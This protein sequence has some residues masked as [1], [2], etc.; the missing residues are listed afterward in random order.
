MGFYGAGDGA[1]FASA[2]VTAYYRQCVGIG[3]G[4]RLF[5]GIVW[6]VVGL[7][8]VARIVATSCVATGA[9]ALIG[10]GTSTCGSATKIVDNRTAREKY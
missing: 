7:E 5:L 8:A 10:A 3:V 1:G 9:G 4:N 2:L 6:L